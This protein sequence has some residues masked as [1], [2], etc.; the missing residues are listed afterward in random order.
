MANSLVEL[1]P[2]AEGYAL[3]ACWSSAVRSSNAI[4][5][6]T[7]KVPPGQTCRSSGSP[8]AASGS[9]G[10]NPT[11]RTPHRVRAGR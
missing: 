9:S 5:G 11:R 3:A 10:G 6:M 4:G 2:P 8:G 7:L 1:N